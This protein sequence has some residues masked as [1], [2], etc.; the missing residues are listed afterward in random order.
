MN[1]LMSNLSIRAKV[2]GAFTM[3]ALIVAG[4]GGFAIERLVRVN[5]AAAEINRDWLP[6]LGGLAVVAQAAEEFRVL[7]A[8][9]LLS[10]TDAQKQ[11]VEPRLKAAA[12]RFNTSFTTYLPTATTA[13]EKH[14]ANAIQLHW[15]AYQDDSRIFLDLSRRRDIETA[16]TMFVSTMAD[17][18]VKLR[19]ALS[20]DIAFNVKGGETA[21]DRVSATYEDARLW[22]SSGIVIAMLVAIGAT[23]V[24]IQN[25]ARPISAMTA[26]MQSL[27]AGD[28][29]VTIPGTDRA[30]EIGAMAASVTVF[31]DNM[32]EAER[33][34][35]AEQRER[36][37]KE[38]R[39]K[40]LDDLT[41]SFET[42]VGTLTD[43]LATAAT[44]LQTTAR[45]MSETAEETSR[46]STAAASAAEQTSANVQTVAAAA[47]ELAS[48]I[49]EIG[50]Q[51][52]Q[53]TAVATKAIDDA[54]RTDGVVQ[55]LVTGAQKVGD[56]IQLIT[57]IASQINLLAL[58]ATIEAAR[59][60][61]AGKGFAVVASEVK[62]LANQTA[63]AT[64][65]IAGQISQIQQ[66]TRQAV[67]AIKEIGVTISEI[68]QIAITIAAAVEE[69][70]SATQE[71]ART[72]QEA[73]S[74][75]QMVTESVG[76]FNRAANDTGIAASQVLESAGS[77]TAQ[78]DQLS[79]E[80]RRFLAGVASA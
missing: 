16:E 15:K 76:H 20:T 78:S 69:Q 26:A 66:A 57:D 53:S 43:S 64:D 37:S 27:S 68:S 3:M 42:K 33:M 79:G 45:A 34:A 2:L 62:S 67:D 75:T 72:V 11:A 52:A 12:D 31:R 59:A 30:D 22:I 19:T 65:E 77:V 44:G 49:T 46:Q 38:A 51:V 73:A 50:R 17:T 13:E 40:V 14:I 54:R 70:Q 36:A 35:E 48:S 80:V 8:I 28:K 60:G 74:G 71:I 56:V 7:E 39:V 47:E 18:F 10:P 24:T 6:A 21:A 58:N 63:K 9:H 55:S 32:I 25:V 29:T 5:E 4:L 41:R 23:L 61:D 1:K